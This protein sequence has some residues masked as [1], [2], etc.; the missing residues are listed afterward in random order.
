VVCESEDVVTVVSFVFVSV[1]GELEVVGGVEVEVTTEVEVEGMTDVLV[2]GAEELV[3]D[4][5]APSPVPSRADDASDKTPET[6]LANC[7]FSTSASFPRPKRAP[8]NQLA[9][10]VMAKKRARTATSRN[11]RDNMAM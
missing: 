4:S 9:C 3:V 7:F 6:T 2:D 8:S 5:V 1:V 11:D 10:V